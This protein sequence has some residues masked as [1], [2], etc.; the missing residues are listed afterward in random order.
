[1]AT[2]VLT[3]D[4]DNWIST[5]ANTCATYIYGTQ[6]GKTYTIPENDA[7][8]FSMTYPKFIE[9]CLADPVCTSVIIERVATGTTDKPVMMIQIP[10]RWNTSTYMISYIQ[11]QIHETVKKHYI[12]L[13]ELNSVKSSVC[14]LVELETQKEETTRK[15]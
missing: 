12:W 13:K 5:C 9:L 2:V 1:M 11:T 7:W 14:D 6:N 3:D 10:R 4:D 8:I 15:L